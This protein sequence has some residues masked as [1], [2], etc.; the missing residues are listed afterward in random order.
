MDF[1]VDC[2]TLTAFVEISDDGVVWGTETFNATVNGDKPQSFNG[3]AFPLELWRMSQRV[4]GDL[5]LERRC[6]MLWSTSTLIGFR[7]IGFTVGF[8]LLVTACGLAPRPVATPTLAP[9]VASTST[10]APTVAP[11][12]T[13]AP[14]A[15]SEP[16]LMVGVG[17][18]EKGQEIFKNTDYVRCEVC[19]SLDGSEFREG[20]SLLGISE[21]AGKRV[22]GL[23]PVEYLRQSILEPS[24]HV[25][26][27]Y[28]DIMKVYQLVERPEG[29]LKALFTL[30]EE[31]LDD[32][33]AF[34]LTQ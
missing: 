25:V 17:D 6:N 33:V 5:I 30:S 19:H 16:T 24:A 1:E 15:T 34:L 26:E 28:E 18:P 32:L 29:P 11:T 7:W 27:G 21:R 4:I 23:S 14:T 20:P 22:P 8:V 31:E 9:P 10:P 13:L 3:V 2:D 12:S